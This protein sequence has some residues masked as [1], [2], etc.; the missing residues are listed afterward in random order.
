MDFNIILSFNQSYFI[1]D[2]NRPI[3]DCLFSLLVQDTMNMYGHFPLNKIF[4]DFYD[5]VSLLIFILFY[6]FS[7]IAKCKAEFSVY[8]LINNGDY[9]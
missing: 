8:T 2:F 4:K 6:F 9:L 5:C 1:R 7:D 3:I